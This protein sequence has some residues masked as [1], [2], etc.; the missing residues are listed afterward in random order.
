MKSYTDLE[1]SKKLAEFLPPESSDMWYQHIGYSIVNG[2]EKLR[3]FPMVRRDCVSDEDIPCWSL[4]A[5]L[6]A[7]NARL[8]NL[9]WA[10]NNVWSVTCCFDK[11]DG[12]L[13]ET[14]NNPLDAVFK[15]ICW[16]KENKEI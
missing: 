14:A 12:Y 7:T 5:L 8:L 15:M 16:L 2:T 10:C 4:T 13:E 3:Y 11:V 1:Q 6:Y 9:H